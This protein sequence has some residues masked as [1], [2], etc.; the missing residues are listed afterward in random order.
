MLLLK[1]RLML[2]QPISQYHQKEKDHAAHQARPLHTG[3]VHA[4]DPK[5]SAAC[6]CSAGP[7][8]VCSL[9]SECRFHGLLTVKLYG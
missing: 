5:C 2:L 4:V 7:L 9:D 3:R 1:R 8:K 6:Q